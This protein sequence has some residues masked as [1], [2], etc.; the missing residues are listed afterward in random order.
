[1]DYSW[2]RRTISGVVGGRTRG[3]RKMCG[4]T[5]T[6]GL[7]DDND[8]DDCC[9]CCCCELDESV[10]V[11][12]GV[13]FDVL[14]KQP[15]VNFRSAN[16]DTNFCVFR[17]GIGLLCCESLATLF[18]LMAVDSVESIDVKLADTSS[19][20]SFDRASSL[21]NVHSCGLISA[22]GFS[23]VLLRLLKTVCVLLELAFPSISLC[24]SHASILVDTP[25]ENRSFFLRV[26]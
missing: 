3:L 11:L 19:F 17:L 6:C 13:V 2:L 26:H 12:I 14:L 4:F 16:F 5:L 8:D 15:P 18:G 9:C 7:N 1:M 24:G 10:T 22:F 20:N 21:S 23:C 25:A